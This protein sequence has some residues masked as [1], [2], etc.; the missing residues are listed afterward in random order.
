MLHRLPVRGM[1]VSR[2]QWQFPAI[3]RWNTTEGGRVSLRTTLSWT[4][5]RNA[6]ACCWSLPAHLH[7][8]PSSALGPP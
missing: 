2:D 4:I 6:L 1:K 5:W 3:P 8:H 7:R